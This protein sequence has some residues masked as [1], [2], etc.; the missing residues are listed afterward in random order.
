[1]IRVEH[2]TWFRALLAEED[3]AI[4]LVQESAVV[5]SLQ[6]RRRG[7]GIEYRVPRSSMAS[8][9][10]FYEMMVVNSIQLMLIRSLPET[11]FMVWLHTL[12][13][14]SKNYQ[15]LSLGEKVPAPKRYV[16]PRTIA[17]ELEGIRKRMGID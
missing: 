13:G 9:T 2:S 3:L 10:A 5:L 17:S 14:Q 6:M 16:L 8:K 11:N 15:K 4:L 1:M 12:G 7:W